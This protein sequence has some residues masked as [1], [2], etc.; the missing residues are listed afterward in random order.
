[1]GVRMKRLMG[2]VLVTMSLSMMARFHTVKSARQLEK[3]V[4][5]YEFSVVCF[6]PSGQTDG[7]D[8]DRD[9]K[10]DRKKEFRAVQDVVKSAS[11]RSEYKKFLSKDV[12]FMVVDVASKQADDLLSEYNLGTEPTCFVFE[13]GAPDKSK[14][15]M[16]PASVKDLTRLLEQE[17]GDSLKKLLK[18]RKQEADLIRQ[19]RISQNYL[20]ATTY[21]Y[22]GGYGW[23]GYGWGGYGWGGYGWRRPYVGWGLYAGY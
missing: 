5:G 8:L 10:I 4:D 13:Q 19:E 1:M 14:K 3:L 6:A 9:D 2:L 11:E 12:G 7:E 21:P 18:D 20:Y 17:G 15:V 22:W 16:R 23:G